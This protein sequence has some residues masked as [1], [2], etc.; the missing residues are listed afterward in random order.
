MEDQF[1]ILGAI[2]LFLS[3]WFH[4]SFTSNYKVCSGHFESLYCSAIRTWGTKHFR[5]W[6]RGLS[7]ALF[8]PSKIFFGCTLHSHCYWHSHFC[9]SF[10]VQGS[11]IEMSM[12]LAMYNFLWPLV[13]PAFLFYIFALI[14]CTHMNQDS[15]QAQKVYC[16][17]QISCSALGI[18]GWWPPSFCSAYYVVA[19]S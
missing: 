17:S 11:F 7:L 10:S 8:L 3:H 19:S 5:L 2:W 6:K 16:T 4:P 13:W 1:P 18:N 14:L 12:Y 9:F 15:M